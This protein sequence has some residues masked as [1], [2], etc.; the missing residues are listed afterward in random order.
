MNI[1]NFF[2]KNGVLSVD[3]RCFYYKIVAKWELLGKSG[4][5]W[6]EYADR[7]ISEYA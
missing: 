4:R 2:V 6:H 3:I 5:Q 1:A 7:R